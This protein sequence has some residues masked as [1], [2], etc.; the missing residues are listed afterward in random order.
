MSSIQKRTY[1]AGKIN[2][3]SKRSKSRQQKYGEVQNGGR[4]VRPG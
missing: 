2:T 4:A 1:G 3:K